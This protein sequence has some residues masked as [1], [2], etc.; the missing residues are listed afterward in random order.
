M[1][2]ASLNIKVKKTKI[3][4]LFICQRNFIHYFKTTN[5]QVFQEERP[6]FWVVIVSVILNKKKKKC[7][8][9]C[10]LLRT[11]FRGIAISLYGSKIVVKREILPTV[12]NTGIYCSSDKVGTV[13]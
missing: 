10:V 11:V 4:V 13:N 12:S 8:Y 2:T 6:I 5:I 3:K 1:L 9:V 7:I